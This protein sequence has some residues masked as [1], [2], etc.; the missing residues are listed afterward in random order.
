MRDDSSRC[1]FSQE[2][3]PQ[4]IPRFTPFHAEKADADCSALS[5][6]PATGYAVSFQLRGG[7]APSASLR[8]DALRPR[9]FQRMALERP[10]RRASLRVWR[11]LRVERFSPGGERTLAVR[12][13]RALSGYFPD[14]PCRR[15]CRTPAPRP[16]PADRWA[17]RGFWLP[18]GWNNSRP[19]PVRRAWMRRAAL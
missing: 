13:R 9:A 6:E 2:R 12:S 19:P 18:A 11:A 15:R 8:A 10:C 7:R 4:H 1:F 14:C 16:A 5:D 17:R 3:F